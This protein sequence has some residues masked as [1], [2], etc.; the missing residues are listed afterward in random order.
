MWIYAVF[1]SSRLSYFVAD[2]YR[3]L[4]GND[5]AKFG[6]LA[7]HNLRLTF[8][9]ASGRVQQTFRRPGSAWPAPSYI[10]LLFIF[11]LMQ[12]IA[13]CIFLIFCIHAMSVF[14]LLLH[15]Y[16]IQQ[17]KRPRIYQEVRP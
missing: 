10:T 15:C 6:K 1:W 12:P 3:Y 5:I 14:V 4:M 9:F 7:K 8:G 16:T 17:G 13:R 11:L 2:F